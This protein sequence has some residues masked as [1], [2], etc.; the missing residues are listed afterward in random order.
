[1]TVKKGSND[2]ELGTIIDSLLYRGDDGVLLGMLNYRG[3][4][5]N[6]WVHPDHQR[7]GI[8]TALLVEAVSRWDD[9]DLLEQDYTF[10][11]KPS[12][13]GVA[14]VIALKDRGVV[15]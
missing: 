11:G 3:G 4:K 5:I 8:G 13:A 15:S 1:M 14:F 10:C 7:Q 2:R 9:I 12:F 6:G